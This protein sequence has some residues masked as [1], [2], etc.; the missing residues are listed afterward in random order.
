MESLRKK[1]IRLKE[2]IVTQLYLKSRD[3][4]KPGR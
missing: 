1:G 2:N 3:Q 4:K